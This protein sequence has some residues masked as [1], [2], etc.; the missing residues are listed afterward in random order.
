M[1]DSSDRLIA[2]PDLVEISSSSPPAAIP[3]R[4]S[5][6]FPSGHVNIFPAIDRHALQSYIND[7]YDCVE[8][9]QD[10]LASYCAVHDQLRAQEIRG[11]RL[12]HQLH[13][14]QEKARPIRQ[15]VN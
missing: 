11:D 3:L 6:S 12:E 14:V 2:R 8:A 13:D 7:L 10:Q 15:H 5:S 1:D 9:G 4:S